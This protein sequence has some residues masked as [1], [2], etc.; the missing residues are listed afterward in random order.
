[1][2]NANA[3]KK[4]APRYV[5]GCTQGSREFLFTEL[6]D[7]PSGMAARDAALAMPRNGTWLVFEQRD[8]SKRGIVFGLSY[9]IVGQPIPASF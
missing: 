7:F 8:V 5:L 3:V 6:G 9:E 4:S 1:M 2:S